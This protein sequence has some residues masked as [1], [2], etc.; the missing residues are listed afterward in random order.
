[1]IHQTS[2][3]ADVVVV[4]AGLAGLSCAREL[5]RDGI[6]VLVCE[7][8]TRVGGRV[9]NVE[10]DGEAVDL[11]G[12]FLGPG[13][14]R[15][16]ALA[17]ELGVP[18]FRMYTS[19]THLAED[20]SGRI[21]RF[22][23][24][25]P[26]LSPVAL[27]DF[28]QAEARFEHLARTV[29]TE[30]PWRTRDAERLDTQTLAGWIRRTLRTANGRR[31]FALAARVLWACE[32]SELSLLHALFYARSAGSLRAVMATE[33]GAQQDLLVGG[34]H[35]L[36]AGLA[37][38]LGERVRLA[39]P[40]RRI[41]QQDDEV[42]VV[43][44]SGQSV[45]AARVV[46]AIPPTLAGRIDYDPPLPPGRDGLTQRLAMGST[47]KCMIVY[48]EPFWRATGLSGH[49]LSLRGPLAAVADS[50]P[51]PARRGVLVSVLE[52]GV[53][54]RLGTNTVSERRA[55]VLDELTRL[56]GPQAGNPS[57]YLERDW[58]AEPFTRGAYSALFPTGAWTQYGPALRAPVGRIHWAGS[59]TA[60]R[61]YGYIDGAIRSGEAAADAVRADRTAPL[62]T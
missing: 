15:A 40:I 1:M 22:R 61:W 47:I 30:A 3:S 56:F 25:V 31:L 27:L 17:G 26:R 42:R 23:G 36:A 51:P 19:G 41:V 52:A 50:S 4:G 54:R 5:L 37:D 11:G 60:T 20:L 43:A 34:A 49:A 10:V 39:M 33:N 18:V 9:E 38:Q 32:P 57:A 16:Y 8:R 2:P 59:E 58:S 62:T 48:P 14:D 13:Q 53:A 55:L 29:D 44:E 24:T 35:Q 45:R 7:A 28:A 46:V 12:Q 21:R 6:D